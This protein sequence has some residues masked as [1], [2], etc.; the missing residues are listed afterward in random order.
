MTESEKQRNFDFEEEEDEAE[1]LALPAPVDE[2]DTVDVDFE[3]EKKPTEFYYYAWVT[4]QGSDAKARN[5]DGDVK[6]SCTAGEILA[7][8]NLV[9]KEYGNKLEVLNKAEPVAEDGTVEVWK[10]FR[11]GGPQ[12]RL[13]KLRVRSARTEELNED[14]SDE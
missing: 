2:E 14:S 4:A 7:V 1:T 12:W 10:T 11:T 3:E 6:V 5:M 9:Q 13:W 8:A